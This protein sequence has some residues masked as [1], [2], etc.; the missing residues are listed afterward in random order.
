MG[1]NF[2]NVFSWL[3]KHGIY[4]TVKNDNKNWESIFLIEHTISN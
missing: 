4:Y 1:Q 2:I 3:D